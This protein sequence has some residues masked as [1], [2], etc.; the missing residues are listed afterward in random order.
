MVL[1]CFK[2]RFMQKLS[3]LRLLQPLRR[4]L[5]ASALALPTLALAQTVAKKAKPAKPAPAASPAPSPIP[6]APLINTP[7]VQ[8]FIARAVVA[9]VSAELANQLLNDSQM[10]PVVK[11]FMDPPPA[12]TRKN[13]AVY[14]ARFTDAL[15][16]SKGQAF[17]RTHAGAFERAS[18]KYGVPP[19]VIAAIIGVETMYGTYLGKFR[20]VDV[21]PTLAFDYP[22]RA[23]FFKDEL[24]AFMQLVQA[25]TLTSGTLGSFAGALGLPQFM[26]GSLKRYGASSDGGAA[27]DLAGKPEDAITSVASFL[28]GHGWVRDMPIAFEAVD[29]D[30]IR[31]A[32]LL[33]P[34]AT[35][36]YDFSV[37]APN[38]PPGTPRELKYAVIDLQH[39][40]GEH[41][42]LLGTQNFHMLMQYNRSYFYAASVWYLARRLGLQV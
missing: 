38:A 21:L 9:G 25:G 31:A 36:S 3:P 26:P 20:L 10:Q 22:R 42:Y 4:T 19:A 11:R 17:L 1:R 34:D 39:A 29:M 7:E 5:L 35:P 6:F 12:G 2:I 27:I 23:E 14:K 13:W 30:D 28:A 41:E 40:T 18:A 15:R 33:K 32:S 16:I 37:V 8:A 24:L